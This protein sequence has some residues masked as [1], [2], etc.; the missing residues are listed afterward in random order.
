MRRWWTL[1]EWLKVAEVWKLLIDY[2][3]SGVGETIGGNDAE[4]DLNIIE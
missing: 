2:G 1:I 3:V 4:A